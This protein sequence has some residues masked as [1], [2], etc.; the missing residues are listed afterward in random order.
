MTTPAEVFMTDVY[1]EGAT[2]AIIRPAAI[3]PEEAARAI[4]VDLALNDA[5]NGG[6]WLASPSTWT[7]FERPWDSATEPGGARQVGT[8]HVA[9]G[10]P[11]RYDITIY[12]VTVTVPGAEAGW[13]VT[14]LTDEALAPG[15]LTLASCPRAS[16][17]APPKP[18]HF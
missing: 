18:F 6:L 16:L 17:P 2:S 3:V 9:Y 13:T 10:T 8:V 5:K 12:R 4:L 14:N 7:R 1:D 11:T 15:G